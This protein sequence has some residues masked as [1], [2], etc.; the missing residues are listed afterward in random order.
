MGKTEIRTRSPHDGDGDSQEESETNAMS[1]TSFVERRLDSTR[2]EYREAGLP[3]QLRAISGRRSMIESMSTAWPK[4]RSYRNSSTGY[5]QSIA[6]D[7]IL[8][9]VRQLAASTVA[10]D[11]IMAFDLEAQLAS[12]DGV[13]PTRYEPPKY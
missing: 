6:A 4:S 1:G 12:H 5:R 13:R 9:A 2:A 3:K 8:L 7:G 11:D 10:F